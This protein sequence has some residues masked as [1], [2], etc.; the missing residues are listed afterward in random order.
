MKHLPQEFLAIEERS[1]FDWVEKGC[2]GPVTSINRYMPQVFE[3]Y[4]HICH[5][6]WQ[7]PGYIPTRWS[8]AVKDRFPEFDG[9]SSWTEIGTN[10]DY[11]NISA[12]DILGPLEGVPPVEAINAVEKAISIVTG[13]EE[14]CIFAFWEGFFAPEQ[15][16]LSRTKVISMSQP[17][18]HFILQAPRAILFDYWRTELENP[19]YTYPKSTPQAVWCTKRQWFYAVPFHDFSS[20]FGGSNK[21]VKILFESKDVESYELPEGHTF[22]Y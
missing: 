7:F 16:H 14:N 22:K 11:D 18:G 19:Y 12:G 3:K 5:P 2:S 1:F 6:A 20:F 10:I 9:K 17:P 8:T 13:P 21:M 4:V 15:L